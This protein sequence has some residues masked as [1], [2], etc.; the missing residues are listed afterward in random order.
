MNIQENK[1]IVFKFGTNVLRNEDKDISLSR[2]YSFIESVS[3]LYKQGKEIIIVT[4]GAVGLGS[5]KLNVDSS[6]SSRKPFKRKYKKILEVYKFSEDEIACIGDQLITDIY[7]A[8]NMGFTS[9]LVN[10]IA[11]FEPI[12]TKINRFFEKFIYHRLAR[13]KLLVKG[14]YYD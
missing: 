1:R 14:E 12:G 3:K 13:K 10:R 8:N 2:V 5:K 4:S 9:I 11:T 7:G 6:Q